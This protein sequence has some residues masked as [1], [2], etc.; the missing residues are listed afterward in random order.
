M[1]KNMKGMVAVSGVLAVLASLIPMATYAVDPTCTADSTTGKI[2]C[3]DS[4]SGQVN[5][6]VNEKLTIDLASPTVDFGKVEPNML[7]K[8]TL[9]VT[10]TSNT[11]YTLA[12]RADQPNLVNQKV[13]SNFIPAASGALTTGE[14]WGIKKKTSAT[15]NADT[16]TAVTNATGGEV[17]YTST[18]GGKTLNTEFEV[19]L[20][21]GSSTASGEYATDVTVIASAVK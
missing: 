18:T 13:S 5:V 21:V 12:F 16:Y 20:I 7:V 4:T 15:V 11:P 8:K 14:G 6:K 19:G 9:S 1:K 3:V 10:V 17:F 2:T